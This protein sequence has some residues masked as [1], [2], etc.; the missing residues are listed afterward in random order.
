MNWDDENDPLV[1]ELRFLQHSPALYH[2]TFLTGAQNLNHGRETVRRRLQELHQWDAEGDARPGSDAYLHRQWLNSLAYF[3]PH[4]FEFR[5]CD[6]SPAPEVTAITEDTHSRALD[7]L[8]QTEPPA[9]ESAKVVSF[10][11]RRTDSPLS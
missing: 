3:N 5:E 2:Q 1:R 10:P 7:V 9:Q 6:P 4:T 8:E 11:I